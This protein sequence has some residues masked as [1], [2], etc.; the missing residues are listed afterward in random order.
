MVSSE[1][2]EELRI[3]PGALFAAAAPALE[4]VFNKT[5]MKTFSGRLT[6]SLPNLEA[7][8]CVQPGRTDLLASHGRTGLQ[9]AA[10]GPWTP[11]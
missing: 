2:E 5:V 10:A 7:V 6:V 3:E 1:P 9:Q 11:C 8:S 4:K